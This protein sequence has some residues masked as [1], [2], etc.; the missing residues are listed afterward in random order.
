MPKRGDDPIPDSLLLSN[1]V[2]ELDRDLRLSPRQVHRMTGL[3]LGDLAEYRRTRPPKRPLAVVSE[4]KG[5]KVW[6]ELGEVLDWRKARKPVLQKPS[7]GI[8]TF[9]AFVARG[10]M[11]DEWVFSRTK[12][13][14]LVDFFASLRLGPLLDYGA[15]CEWL[16]LEDFIEESQRWAN[17]LKA[18]AVSRHL[19]RPG[20]LPVP[21][22]TSKPACPKCGRAMEDAH[23]CRL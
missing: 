14:Q 2:H 6:Y 19:G 9:T 21:E 17:E 1:G 13:G 10:R 11:D 4:K 22:A 5:A 23:R 16:T 15:D 18:Q 3:S 12:E 7:G 20:L 8:K